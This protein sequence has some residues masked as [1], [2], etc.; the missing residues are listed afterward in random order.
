MVRNNDL[1]YVKCT[2]YFLLRLFHCTAMLV[3]F[4]MKH[5]VDKEMRNKSPRF[6][7]EAG[8]INSGA[9]QIEKNLS[10]I[11]CDRKGE[12]VGRPVLIAIAAIERA[13]TCIADDNKT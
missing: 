9:P 8:S 7:V 6:F 5:G 4:Q 13:R 2:H 10:L 12:D 3:S 1:L 11:L